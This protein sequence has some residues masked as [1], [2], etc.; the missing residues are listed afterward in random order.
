M[1]TLL[2]PGDCF[3]GV[4]TAA[5]DPDGLVA[6]G[7]DLSVDTL[8]SAY[9]H[10]IFPWYSE[11]PILWW[12]PDPRT[13]LYLEAFRCSRS[14]RKSVHNRGY[15]ATFD[16]HFEQVMRTSAAC[17]PAVG[18]WIHEEM[19]TAYVRLHQLGYA[20]SV[21]IWHDQQIVG[22][23]Y[24]VSIGRC[25]FGESMFH[26]K[27]D[28]SKVALFYLILFLK[29]HE[30]PWVDCQMPTQH[31]LSLGAQNLSRSQYMVLLQDSIMQSPLAA[32]AWQQAHTVCQE[33][34][35]ST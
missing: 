19:V 24:G 33:S 25:F 10:G 21:E 6:M 32:H 13:V 4:S 27:V 9:R 20:H 2:A 29:K 26:T 3:S 28:A 17:R 30:I 1:I 8:L 12:S 22:G 31:L 7:G 35:R 18:S 5:E 14:L 23:L 15:V 11:P 16:G 34:M